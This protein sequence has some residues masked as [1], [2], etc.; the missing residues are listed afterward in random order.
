MARGP[1]HGIRLPRRRAPGPAPPRIAL[2]LNAFLRQKNLAMAAARSPYDILNVA[3]SAEGVVIEAAYRALMKKYHPDQASG[4]A[5]ADG[6]SA[7]EINAAFSLLRDPER[8]AAYDQGEWRR[9]QNMLIAQ[10]QPPPTARRASVFGWSGWIVALILGVMV[11]ILG[12]R[13]DGAPA[14]EAALA[15]PD[16]RSQP[17]AAEE[18]LVSPAALAEIRAEAFGD[19]SADAPATAPRRRAT[20]PAA[21]TARVPAA[22]VARPSRQK[23]R[24]RPAPA[25]SKVEEKDFLE[26]EGYIY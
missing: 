18:S 8:R 7:A 24:P 5:E 13:T 4:P 22:P 14:T 17:S 16:F 26:R 9:Q 23:P 20:K 12:G 25:R 6:A 19:R 3:P 1:R 10:Y 21:S 15:E 2:A 11:A